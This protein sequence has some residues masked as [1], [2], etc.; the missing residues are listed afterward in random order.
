M[1]VAGL[2]PATIQRPLNALPLLRACCY[3]CDISFLVHPHYRLRGSPYAA[4][5]RRPGGGPPSPSWRA[6][7]LLSYTTKMWVIGT[8]AAASL[9]IGQG[10][11][12]RSCSGR[13]CK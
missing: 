13:W 1:V 5:F 8:S 3:Q 4:G 7:F 9:A 10:S 6:L 2:E 12:I 11:H